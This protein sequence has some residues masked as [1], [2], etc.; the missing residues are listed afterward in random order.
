MVTPNPETVDDTPEQDPI[1]LID[2]FSNAV[3]LDEAPPTLGQL[4]AALAH[5]RAK[6]GSI[7]M[8]TP[9]EFDIYVK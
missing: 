3:G 5:L 8:D 9:R 2:E 1:A 6:F 4:K 7:S